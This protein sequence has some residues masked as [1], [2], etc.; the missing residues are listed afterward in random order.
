MVT[1]GR[2]VGKADPSPELAGQRD[3]PGHR[4]HCTE[5]PEEL[6][7]GPSQARQQKQQ[8]LRI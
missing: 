5:E 3:R 2:G 4:A 1:E 7:R 8:L 6:R